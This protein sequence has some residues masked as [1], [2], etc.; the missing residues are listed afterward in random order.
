[1]PAVPFSIFRFS[2]FSIAVKPACCCHCWSAAAVVLP[3]FSLPP[4]ALAAFCFCLWPGIMLLVL[5]IF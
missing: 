2:A 5:F 4:V 1:M 3:T